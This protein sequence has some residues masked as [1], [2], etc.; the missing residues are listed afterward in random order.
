MP[1]PLSDPA[2]RR[3][4]HPPLTTASPRQLRPGPLET[5]YSP[6][7]RADYPL[8]LPLTSAYLSILPESGHHYLHEVPGFRP[9]GPT[10]L[11]EP[12]RPRGLSPQ[13]APEDRL[14][15]TSEWDFV[16]RWATEE[17]PGLR[18]GH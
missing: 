2:R 3:P 12:C 1:L 5:P 10:R 16:C 9:G 15:G 13:E 6:E 17:L 8:G 7:G 4:G 14:P 18:R 11:H